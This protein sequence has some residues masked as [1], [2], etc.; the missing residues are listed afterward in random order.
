MRSRSC[1]N[2]C[3]W[4]QSQPIKLSDIEI[5][6]ELTFIHQRIETTAVLPQPGLCPSA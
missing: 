3:G 6:C 5:T 1:G 2:G 4:G